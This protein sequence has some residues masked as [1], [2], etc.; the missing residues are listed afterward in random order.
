MKKFAVGRSGSTIGSIGSLSLGSLGLL[1][2]SL[3]KVFHGHKV[4]GH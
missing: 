3:L 4:Q 1:A 2:L